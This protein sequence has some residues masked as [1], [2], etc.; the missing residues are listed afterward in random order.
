MLRI[1]NLT[2]GY[3]PIVA[4]KG[5][6]LHVAPGEIVT[7]LGA[8][9]SG[10]STLLATLAGLIRA[11]SGAISLRGQDVTGLAAEKLVRRGVALVPEGRQLFAP[12]TVE[13]NLLL[14]AYARGDN[15]RKA[16][17]ASV[18]A[19]FPILEERRAQAVGTLSGG[20][21]QML[22]IGRA[23]MSR[24]R[25]LLLDEPS[26][27]LAPKIA[28]EIFRKLRHLL[29]DDLSILLVE[30]DAHL[31][32]RSADRGYV[33]ETGRIVVE[34][35]CDALRNNPDVQRAYLGRGYQEGWEESEK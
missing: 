2:S 31:A 20:Q 11:M 18:Y 30:Q 26:M 5:V 21:Q 32:L 14:G 8:N 4:L 10:K 34:G 15:D 28:H 35:D 29:N 33:L 7:L 17:M 3:G 24:P 1:E 27:G 19:L 13:E 16:E 23:M 25:L 9:G 22:A 6:T 12:M